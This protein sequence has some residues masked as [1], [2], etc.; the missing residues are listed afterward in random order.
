M[1]IKSKDMYH[2]ISCIFF[3]G[4]RD[5]F[6]HKDIFHIAGY[7]QFLKVILSSNHLSPG[8]PTTKVAKG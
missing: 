1:K 4:E 7:I 6:K 2:I 3:L 8:L 5:I